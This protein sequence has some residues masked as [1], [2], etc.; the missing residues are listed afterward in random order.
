MT[1]DSRTAGISANI[2]LDAF[3]ACVFYVVTAENPWQKGRMPFLQGVAVF[4]PVMLQLGV[5][6][7]GRLQLGFGCSGE[8]AS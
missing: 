7:G 5:A 3:D 6:V 8:E 1:F 2:A 4:F